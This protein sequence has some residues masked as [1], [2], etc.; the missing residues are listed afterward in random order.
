MTSTLFY[1]IAAVLLVFF[2][3]GHT[4]GFLHFVPTTA[5]GA[6]VRDAMVNVQFPIG[7]TNFTYQSFYIGFG[8][9][10]SAYLLFAAILAWQLGVFVNGAPDIVRAIGWMLVAVQAVCLVLSWIY[11]F[12]APV[13]FSVL[14]VICLAVAA[15]LIP[16]AAR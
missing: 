14:V 2:A 15:W 9:F 5:E 10:V 7:R 11:F 16:S 8:L 13:I 1:R 4:I 12:P 3:I 6:A